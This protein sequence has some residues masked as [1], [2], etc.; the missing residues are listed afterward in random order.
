[1]VEKGKLEQMGTGKGT[2]MLKRIF[3]V[4]YYQQVATGAG[5]FCRNQK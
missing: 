3:C 5:F 2:S 4:E 1:L